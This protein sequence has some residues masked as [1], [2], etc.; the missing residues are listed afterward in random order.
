M[1]SKFLTGRKTWVKF[2]VCYQYLLLLPAAT[3]G[4]LANRPRVFGHAGICDVFNVDL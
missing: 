2:M 1:A 3:K 4:S